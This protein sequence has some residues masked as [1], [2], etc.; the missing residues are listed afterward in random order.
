MLNPY[1]FKHC[2]KADLVNSIKN[3][4]ARLISI[5]FPNPVEYVDQRQLTEYIRTQY[6]NKV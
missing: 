5:G 4:P 1:D 6:E 2:L 3:L